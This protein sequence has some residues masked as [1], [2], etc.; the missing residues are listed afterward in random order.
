MFGRVFGA[1]SFPTRAHSG[2][3][4]EHS[5][6][7]VA[8][9][10]TALP[11]VAQGQSV[12]EAA[13]EQDCFTAPTAACLFAEADRLASAIPAA[14]SRAETLVEIAAEYS[15]A[16]IE[17]ADD[18]ARANLLRARMIVLSIDDDNAWYDIAVAEARL[19]RIASAL[20]AS[21]HIGD[22]FRRN[23]A[24]SVISSLQLDAGDVPGALHAAERIDDAPLRA[25][26]LGDVAGARMAAGDVIGALETI[27]PIDDGE[28]RNSALR[29]VAFAQAEAGDLDGALQT[30]DGIGSARYS[31]LTL[32]QLAPAQARAGDIQGALAAAR[33][34]T[35]TGARDVV[36]AELIEILVRA[37]RFTDALGAAGEMDSNRRRATF[38][39][40]V[41]VRMADLAA[42]LQTALSVR[43]RM[44]RSMVLSGIAGEQANAG[45]I[46]GALS[47]VANVDESLFR[48]IALDAI[49]DAQA[50]AGDIAEAIKT[51]KTGPNPN[52]YKLTDIAV[53]QVGTGDVRGA[54][55][56]VSDLGE[57]DRAVA[58]A[59]IAAE[60]SRTR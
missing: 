38:T 45:D 6:L 24:L 8:G 57:R 19:G 25:T 34:M 52:A 7:L 23:V 56:T 47:T 60:V 51:L 3:R 21:E 29:Q 39:A 49:A 36:L 28:Q 40:R 32:G 35:D 15:G 10:L 14:S 18:L 31:S 2:C 16:D 41:Q 1:L 9:I 11:F 44:G 4:H 48:E 55:D 59:R 30:A 27:E 12:R 43:D 22:A 17:N 37:D 42:A 20:D 46:S 50:D 33:R 53:R 26:A 58:L 13:G 54:I 5:A